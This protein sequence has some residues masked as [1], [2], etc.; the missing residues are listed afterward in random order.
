MNLL[1]LKYFK[2]YVSMLKFV[3]V[4]TFKLEHFV[5]SVVSQMFHLRCNTDT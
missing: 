3:E 1:I 4:L 2:S 5:F